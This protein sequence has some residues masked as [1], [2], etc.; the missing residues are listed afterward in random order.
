M[1][2]KLGRLSSTDPR[3]AVCRID[4]DIWHRVSVQRPGMHCLETISRA[5]DRL[6]AEFMFAHVDARNEP[7]TP[8]PP[9][10]PLSC[11]QCI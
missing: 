1:I 2:E 5:A 3:C 4:L 10:P 9:P 6:D 8:S 7:A 11:R